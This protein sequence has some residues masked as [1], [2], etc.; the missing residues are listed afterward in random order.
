MGRN[1]LTESI[2]YKLDFRLGNHHI[3]IITLFHAVSKQIL[4]TSVKKQD[5]SFIKPS[6]KLK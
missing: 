5:A 2:Y 4:F 6:I 3:N 1:F